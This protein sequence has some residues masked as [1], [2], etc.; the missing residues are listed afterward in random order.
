M[1]R[2]KTVVD[3]QQLDILEQ[4][5]VK[6]TELIRSLRRERE[7]VRAKLQESQEALAQAHSRSAASEKERQALQEANEQLELLKE[8]RV[9]IRGKVSRMLDMM[10][11]LEEATVESQRDH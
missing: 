3:L 6:A 4:K 1:E 7:T 9:E 8:E 5:I 2:K 11:S 10:A